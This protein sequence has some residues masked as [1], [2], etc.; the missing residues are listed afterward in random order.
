MLRV[1]RQSIRYTPDDN[2]LIHVQFV[3]GTQCTG[4]AYSEAHKGCAGVFTK[5]SSFMPEVNCDLSIG[6]IK[7][8]SAQVRWVEEVDD[9]LIKVGFEFI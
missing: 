4:L 3:D 5:K 8:L 2:T 6:E 7:N 1:K 9:K